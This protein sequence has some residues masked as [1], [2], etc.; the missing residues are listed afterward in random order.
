M[1][2]RRTAWTEATA[3]RTE[4]TRRTIVGGWC[5]F[6]TPGDF[7]SG[8]LSQRTGVR[9]DQLDEVDLPAGAGLRKQWCRVGCATWLQRRP[10][11]RVRLQAG[12][13]QPRRVAVAPNQKYRKQPHAK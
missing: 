4:M 3:A 9:R 11:W 12:F 5:H 2:W 7:V 6:A 8:G 13:S 10:R 1:Y